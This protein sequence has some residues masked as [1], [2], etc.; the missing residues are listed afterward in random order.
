M[1][2][3]SPTKIACIVEWDKQGMPH[4]DIAST[5]HIH[6]TTVTW[7]LKWFEKSKD[8]YHINHKTCIVNMNK[9]AL[10]YES[11]IVPKQCIQIWLSLREILQTCSHA[12]A[13]SNIINLVPRWMALSLRASMDG[14]DTL[15]FSFDLYIGGK[16]SVWCLR[17]PH[18][19]VESDV[20]L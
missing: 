18:L 7:I 5:I 1:V 20:S 16:T 6:Q 17:E 12:S 2:Y 9:F 8:Y 4:K 10:M 3:T 13:K 15:D 11:D 14:G 19:M